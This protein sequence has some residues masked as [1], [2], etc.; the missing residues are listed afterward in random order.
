MKAQIISV[1]QS[2]SPTVFPSSPTEIIAFSVGTLCAEIA[3][4]HFVI[5]KLTTYIPEYESGSV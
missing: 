2:E 5:P 4:K 3:K 1:Y